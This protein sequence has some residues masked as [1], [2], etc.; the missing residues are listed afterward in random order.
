MT[1]G[2]ALHRARVLRLGLESLMTRF[3]PTTTKAEA[4]DIVRQWIDGRLWRRE[5]H[6]AE[7]GGIAF[8]EPDEIETMGRQDA[9][10]LDALLR[11]ADR[12]FAGEEKASIA[13]A[14]GPAAPAR[15]LCRDCQRRRPRHRRTRRSRDR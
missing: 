11:L 6:L 13:R 14:L 3:T 9:V 15:C 5:A 8:L 12:M 1:T 2:C 4:E 7:T 10:E